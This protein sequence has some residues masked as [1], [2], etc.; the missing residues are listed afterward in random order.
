M[1]FYRVSLEH[2][3]YGR[4][5]RVIGDQ[6]NDNLG[7]DRFVAHRKSQPL[8]LA[9]IVSHDDSDAMRITRGLLMKTTA[10]IRL[11]DFACFF[12]LRN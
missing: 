12:V 4:E 7:R 11:K 5:P 9:T 1:T 10:Q 8:A 6:A 2:L 3:M